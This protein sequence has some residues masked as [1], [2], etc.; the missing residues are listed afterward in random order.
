MNVIFTA[1]RSTGTYFNHIYKQTHG[2][3]VEHLLATHTA[4]FGSVLEPGN[5]QH[6]FF[7][8]IFLDLLVMQKMIFRYN[9]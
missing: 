4:W 8:C 3:E 9:Q 6:L 2:C 5:F 1:F 7:I